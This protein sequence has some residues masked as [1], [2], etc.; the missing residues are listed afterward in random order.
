MVTRKPVFAINWTEVEALAAGSHDNPHHI[1]GMHE[2]SDG[3]Y[4]NAYLPDAESVTAV[5]KS[6]K[7]KYELVSDRITGFY[8][9][10][11]EN[12]S[13]FVYYFE[14]VYSD[15]RKETVIDPYAFEPVLDPID[16]S[17]FNEG[18]HYEIYEN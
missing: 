16:I 14:V 8:S 2:S 12:E 5:R 13:S 7:E 9:V 17:K 3:V 6:D 1:L 11:I 4:I 18:I 15:G 10:K